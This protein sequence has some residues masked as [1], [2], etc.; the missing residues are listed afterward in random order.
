MNMKF[1]YRKLGEAN[2]PNFTDHYTGWYV[3]LD[4]PMM[5]KNWHGPFKTKYTAAKALNDV[6]SVV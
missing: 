6:F 2:G 3:R 1:E 5:D 4:E